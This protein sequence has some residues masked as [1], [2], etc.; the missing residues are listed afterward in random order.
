MFV[1]DHTDCRRRSHRWG[2]GL[3]LIA[4]LILGG[5]DTGMKLLVGKPT[6]SEPASTPS[7]APVPLPSTA[8]VTDSDLSPGHSDQTIVPPTLPPDPAAAVDDEAEPVAAAGPHRPIAALPLSTDPKALAALGEAANR[9][10][11]L[12]DARFVL[13]VLTPPAADAAAFDRDSTLARQAANAALKALA[14]AGIPPGHVDASLATGAGVDGGALRL[15][16]R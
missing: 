1:P 15:Y 11:N 3:A 5:C 10:A 13:L 12:Q 16:R 7:A 14:D 4:P 9:E 8:F 6:G 2:A